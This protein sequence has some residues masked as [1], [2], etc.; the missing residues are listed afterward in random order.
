[1]ICKL[2][3]NE[4]Y[5]KEFED[6]IYE[7][8]CRFSFLS[9]MSKIYTIDLSNNKNVEIITYYDGWK[10]T[11]KINYLDGVSQEM[12]SIERINDFEI[13]KKFNYGLNNYFFV[14]E[15]KK[16]WTIPKSHLSSNFLR[17]YKYS[18]IIDFELIENGN[19]ISK[20][21]IGRAIIG[22]KLFGDVGA[23]VGGSTGK[24]TNIST[25]NLL[26]IK[27]TVRDSNNPVSYINF[28]TGGNFKKNESFYKENFNLA[29]Q[30]L[31]FLQL[32]CDQN[33]V[34][35][36]STTENSTNSSAD[37]IKKYKELLDI[38]AITQEE[39][40]IKKKQLLDL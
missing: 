20:G 15:N 5:L 13:T 38:G 31:S 19:S 30:I 11:A 27:I 36:V 6:G 40:D 29:Q 14:D 33:T 17:V 35:N 1:M 10:A 34:N 2:D 23:I 21:G 32:M 3:K 22:G 9:P 26:R 28:I 12:K 7:F 25:C 4:S 39:F 18:D 16:E 8:K 24:R 37:E